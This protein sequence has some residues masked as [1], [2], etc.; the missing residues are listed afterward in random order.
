MLI[1][2]FDRDF[3]QDDVSA[4]A[5]LLSLMLFLS[6]VVFYP[7]IFG[8]FGQR[9]FIQFL[10]LGHFT[11]KILWF[12]QILF[13]IFFLNFWS[14]SV[15]NNSVYRSLCLSLLGGSF[16]WGPQKLF[17]SDLYLS[18]IFLYYKEKTFLY[19]IFLFLK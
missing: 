7:T 10:F 11:L 8:I 1:I 5:L 15:F 12:P 19:Y 13:L 18:A 17:L 3:Q 6:L 16:W 9:T 14:F 4:T 2:Y